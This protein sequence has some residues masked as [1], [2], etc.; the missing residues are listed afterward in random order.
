MP[1]PNWKNR[2]IWTG[3]NLDVLRGMNSQ[4]VDLIY[5]D[6]PFNSNKAFSAPIGSEA[7][8]AAFKDTWHLSEIDIAWHGE[9]AD[10]EPS[11][12]QYL[13]GIRATH[14]KGMK[15]YLIMMAVRLLEMRRVLR[16]NGSLYLHCD[17][18][19]GHYLKVLLDCVF[20]AR[21]FRNSITWQR[22][23]SHNDAKRYGRVG[24]HIL[25]YAGPNAIW[26]PQFQP[27]DAET[28]EK[29]YRQVD[30]RGRF[31]TSPL[32]ARTLSGGGYEFTWRGIKDVWKFP[33]H[34]LNELENEGRIYWPPR[35]RIPRRKVY[36]DENRGRPLADV[37]TDIGIA[38]GKERTGYPTQKP[39]ALLERLI[40]ASSNP[41]GVVLDPFCGCATALVAAERLGRQ[42]AGI[43]L[44]PKA[45]DLVRARLQNEAAIDAGAKGQQGLLGRLTVLTQPL[46]RTDQGKLS[47]YRTHKHSLYGRQ[48]GRCAGCRTHFPFRN[49][50]VD[51]VAPR[52]KG[53]GDHMENLQLLCNACNSAKGDREQS[54]LIAKLKAQGTI[55]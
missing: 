11:L 28:I 14:S 30:D 47:D 55:P 29:N 16:P 2:T 3:D 36:L 20:G 10:R 44:S 25:F 15:A 26:N 40:S 49:M 21:W 38:S 31:T 22:Y 4:S 42:W 23:G 34:R 45:V 7:A 9:I 32:Q 52:S 33:E 37:M 51:H 39:L 19:A 54:Y 46:R 13:A 5:L 24:D 27:L 43:D 12:Y 18:A 50:T 1:E 41:D 53:G 6:P 48:E 8:G 35:G 17:D